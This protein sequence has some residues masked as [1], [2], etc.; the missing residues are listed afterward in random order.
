MEGH[1]VFKNPVPMQFA[2]A[3]LK[4]KAALNTMAEL[5]RI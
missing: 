5:D 2:W 3:R 1:V 4:E